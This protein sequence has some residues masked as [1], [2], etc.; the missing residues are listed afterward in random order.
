MPTHL[1]EN[2]KAAANGLATLDADGF[3]E[4][5]QIKGGYSESDI[6]TFPL[7]GVLDNRVN[8]I[9]ENRTVVS[10]Q[11]TDY[12]TDFTV[13]NQHL[14]IL[15]NSITTGGDIVIT[16]ASIDENT[17]VVTNADTETIT[18]DTTTNQYYQSDK[19]WWEITNIDVSSGAIT[20]INYDVGVLGYV[21]LLN[22]DFKI[23]GYRVDTRSQDGGNASD[24]TFE[25]IKVQDDGGKKMSF[26]TL[27]DIGVDSNG[28]GNQIIDN[29]RT[30]ADD[31]SF[32]PAV[33]NIWLNNTNLSFKQSDFDTYFTSN[34]NEFES[35]T[36][37][38]GYILTLSGA[39]AG[40]ITGV[41]YITIRIDFEPL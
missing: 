1:T 5:S 32:N 2:D 3:L 26:V 36:K 9:G 14:F 17:G 13:S 24:F 15:V 33:T 34:Q 10:S 11:T 18:V 4:S 8:L 21:D 27:E 16:G 35:S 39:P 12:A 6:F 22:K 19:K 38:E 28:I 37:N 7:S 23:T 20:S 40:G 25:L 31:R 41:D 30:G 29:L